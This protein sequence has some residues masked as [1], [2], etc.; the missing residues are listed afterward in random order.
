MKK[1]G[2][3]I[4]QIG[5]DKKFAREYILQMKQA[6]FKIIDQPQ[7]FYVKSEGFRF[8]EKAAK[9]KR[10]YYLHSDAYEYCVSNVHAIEKTDDMVQFEKVEKHQRI[11]LFDAS[12][13]RLA[14][15]YRILK[16]H[17]KQRA[18]SGRMI[19]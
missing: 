14:D 3:N 5:H 13:L 4:K 17:Q 16:G 8:I 11:D 19:N 10:L 9:D 2:F 6:G 7:Y 12:V 18:G 1:M 15:I